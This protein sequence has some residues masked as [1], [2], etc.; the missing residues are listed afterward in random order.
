MEQLLT[1]SLFFWSIF[2]V[3]CGFNSLITGKN[4]VLNIIYGVLNINLAI[5][6]SIYILNE[7]G[8]SRLVLW[9]AFFNFIGISLSF[10]GLK[11]SPDDEIQ[12]PETSLVNN[13]K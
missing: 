5:I 1:M 11:T 3:V 10:M 12:N 6:T 7:S 2:N 13:K 4:I 9:C 8:L